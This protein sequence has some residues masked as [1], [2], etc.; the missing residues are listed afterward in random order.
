VWRQ[1]VIGAG[2]LAGYDGVIN[3]Y[4]IRTPS[5]SPRAAMSD[6]Q[7]AAENISGWR[8]WVLREIVDYRGTDLF[9]PR[10]LGTPLARLLRDGV[11]VTPVP[12]GL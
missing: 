9:S 1:Q 6:D 10:D 5:F 11:P 4:V 7:L 12:P 2:Y 3:D 8:W